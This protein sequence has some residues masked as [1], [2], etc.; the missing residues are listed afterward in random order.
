MTNKDLLKS[1]VLLISLILATASFAEGGR[2]PLRV[3]NGIVT[4]ASRL[5]SQAGVDAMQAGGNAV[6]AAIATAFALAVTW[7]SAGNIGGGGFM[8]Y[9]GEDGDATTFDFRE[10][11]PLAATERM[12]LGLDGNV[13]NNSNHMGALS[14][15][16]P[17]TVAGLWKAHQERG[18]LPWEQLVAPAIKL[19]REGIPITYALQSGFLS[20]KS[21]F[22][23]YPSSQ[24]KFFK[25]DG[26][27]FELGELWVQEDLAHTLELIQKNGRDGFY[28]GENAKRL[29]DYM[30]ANGGIITEED[31]EI[32]QPVERAPVR[33]TYRG[34]EIVSVPPPS[35]GGVALIQMLNIL[36]GYD[37]GAMGHNSSAYLHVLTES[38]RRAYADR[39]EHLG[40]PD[41]NEAMPIA[42]LMDK[43]YAAK[44]R[45]TIDMAKA[46][47]SDPSKFAEPYESEETTHFSVVDKDGNMVSMTYTLE[48]GY[49]SAMVVAGGGYLLNNEMGDFNAMPGVTNA[50]GA[51][52]TAPNLV[53]PQKRM[54]SSMTP[55]IVAKDGKPVFT[56]GSPG[57]KTIINTTMQ[58]ILNVI[59]HGMN[60]AESVEAGRIHHQWLPDVTSIE[61]RAVSAD[62]LKLYEALGHPV[63]VRGEQGAA[64]AVYHDREAGLF[65]GA[66]D[67][68]R[69]DGAAVGY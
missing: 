30:A 9:H 21:R 33:G 6:D 50:R 39:A 19:A 38:M 27:S 44:Q 54:L 69:G 36:E 14:V 55:T 5:A 23:L 61:E 43:D 68:R 25:A 4:S 26:S 11:A 32:Y 35:S 8:V 45:A 20:N 56:A 10:K 57:G 49:G 52:G 48:Y 2:T 18:S 67:S 63:R 16:V 64:M 47:I 62:S 41:F 31:L 58:L 15:G 29:A 13:V 65:L 60:I 24:Q 22:D 42:R 46:D 40:D 7:P 37:L 34:Y 12:F 59:D 28:K 53:A 3:K 1:F 51:I 17:G 66:S